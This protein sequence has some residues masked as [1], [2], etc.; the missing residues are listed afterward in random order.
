MLLIVIVIEF[1]VAIL[2]WR[3]EAGQSEIAGMG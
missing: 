3:P 2:V 1:A